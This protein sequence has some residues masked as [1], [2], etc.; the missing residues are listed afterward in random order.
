MAAMNPQ[1]GSAHRLLT[2]DALVPH[3]HRAVIV[4]PHPDDEV[5]G[6]AG[7]MMQ[8][9]A[10]GRALLLVA[11]T[12]GTA[13]HPDSALWPP[14]R[15]AMVRP[16]ETAHALRE[17]GVSP[18]VLRTQL[19]DG[20]VRE[21]CDAL[22]GRLCE[23]LHGNDVVI[24]TWRHDAHPDHEAV[25]A[26][27]AAAAHHCGARCVEVPIWGWR[28]LAHHAGA[29]C[30]PLDGAM[31]ARKHRAIRAFVS[32]LMGDASTGR[33][34]ILPASALQGWLRPFEVYLP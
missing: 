27:C 34:P 29:R 31:L 1:T 3:G 15:L 18:H 2:L 20:A 8:A 30:L 6:M 25:G 10:Q 19:P 4:A 17:L 9:Q 23:T 16:R 13:S 11:V 28:R 22:R 33:G 32:Q 7:L 12:D 26:A 21:Q 14:T 24:T 5:L